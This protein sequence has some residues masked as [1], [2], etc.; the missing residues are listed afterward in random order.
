MFY[1]VHD[2]FLFNVLSLFRNSRE[3]FRNKVLKSQQRVK[4][5]IRIRNLENRLGCV[6]LFLLSI[7][8]D[9]QKSN[10]QYVIWNHSQR[11]NEETKQKL[12]DYQLFNKKF[13]EVIIGSVLF[14]FLRFV[15][16]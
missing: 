5:K 12:V 7:D 14:S 4:W 15:F 13:I 3:Q 1:Q 2:L 10:I 9:V 11:K 16:E 8:N 6:R